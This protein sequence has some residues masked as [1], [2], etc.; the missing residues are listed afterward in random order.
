M[1]FFRKI[2]II[3]I[4]LSITF[5]ISSATDEKN[6]C[7]IFANLKYNQQWKNGFNIVNEQRETDSNFFLTKDEQLE[8]IDNNS[9]NTALLNLKKYCCNHSNFTLWPSN[10]DPTCQND[11]TFFNENSLDSPYLFDHIFD[12]IM[13]RLSWLTWKNNIYTDSINVDT[14]W[15]ERRI[16]THQRIENISWSNPQEIINKYKEFRSQSQLKNWYDISQN[17]NAIFLEKSNNEFLSYVKWEWWSD[18]SKN[19]ANA[20]KNY[21]NRSLYDRYNNACAL[22]EFFYAFLSKWG[23]SK[24]VNKIR[25][26]SNECQKIVS[27]QISSE[28]KYTSL[29]IKKSSNLS[30]SN[31]I[32]SYISYLE[33]RSNNL[34]TIR[35]NSSD[36]FL[37]V[38]RN[39]SM[40]IDTC[41]KW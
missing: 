12:I 23:Y 1:C 33:N 22:S 19:V 5:N 34:K 26:L 4:I 29:I 38:V 2:L 18:E 10:T 9:L 24:D 36:R 13:R 17:V 6:D 16:Q 3:S 28:V 27:S 37:D 11:A 32:N 21:K 25:K 41:T 31:S 40:L 8:I 30:L 39:V 20:L 14:K 35:K 15:Q 7:Q